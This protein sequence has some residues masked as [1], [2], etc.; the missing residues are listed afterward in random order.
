MFRREGGLWCSYDRGTD[1]LGPREGF[2]TVF[3][4]RT[5]S[6]PFLTF[7][8]GR[9]GR[10]SDCSSHPFDSVSSQRIP[11][12]SILLVSLHY[13]L[14]SVCK[15]RSR[16]TPGTKVREN[17]EVSGVYTSRGMDSY[18]GLYDRSLYSLTSF[19]VSFFFLVD[20]GW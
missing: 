14:K 19:Y 10:R 8:Q 5:M 7:C 4:L 13:S 2:Q 11:L 6:E 17:W 15:P 18:C 3:V 1:G 20:L 16:D 9:S 12:T